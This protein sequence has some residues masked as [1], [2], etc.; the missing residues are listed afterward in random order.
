MTLDP[1][2]I[3]AYLDIAAVIAAAAGAAWYA[4]FNSRNNQRAADDSVSSN[5]IQ[6][7]KTTSDMQEKMIGTLT[8]KLDQTTKELHVMQG[9]NT[10][11]EELFNGSE[12]SILSFL[13]QAPELITIAKENHDLSKKNADDIAALTASIGK[14]VVALTAKV[15]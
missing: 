6:N 3:A 2:N 9:R 14:L 5:L 7:L 1:Q 8:T 10:V 13:K 11:L 12:N 15:A 4:F